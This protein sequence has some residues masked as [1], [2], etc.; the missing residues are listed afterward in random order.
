MTLAD[1]LRD[2]QARNN[3]EEID[4]IKSLFMSISLDFTNIQNLIVFD[5]QL[6]PEK[7]EELLNLFGFQLISGKSSDYITWA[8]HNSIK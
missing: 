4:F 8:R 6:P 2:V 5:H 1:I 7:A 3:P